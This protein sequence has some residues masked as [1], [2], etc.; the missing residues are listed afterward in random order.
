MCLRLQLVVKSLAT[1][2]FQECR[3]TH[4]WKASE[5]EN[6]TNGF[7][8]PQVEVAAAIRQVLFLPT[9][10]L[11]PWSCT[12]LSACSPLLLGMN[13]QPQEAYSLP[14]LVPPHLCKSTFSLLLPISR[15]PLP[16]FFPSMCKCLGPLGEE[17]SRNTL[18]AQSLQ[19]SLS[20]RAYGL[21][22]VPIF[23]LSPFR[24]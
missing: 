20:S 22:W 6:V 11:L 8:R 3:F 9:R 10:M 21:E 19:K 17:L 16:P 1:V 18:L 12:T 5:G 23:L 7:N 15:S 13:T 2:L 14:P 4:R 24:F